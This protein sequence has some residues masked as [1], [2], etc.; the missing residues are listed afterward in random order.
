MRSGRNVHG[1]APRAWAR[2]WPGV[3]VRSGCDQE[4]T[5]TTQGRGCM[6][7]QDLELWARL[8]WGAPWTCRAASAVSAARCTPPRHGRA[9]GQGCGC[10][11]E[12]T[13]TTRGRR[14]MYGQELELWAR[15]E[16]VEPWTGRAASAAS[17]ASAA[18]CTP[19]PHARARAWPGVWV[20]SGRHVSALADSG[21]TPTWARLRSQTWFHGR[22]GSASNHKSQ[23]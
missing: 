19:S 11:P 17:A 4:G 3:R 21:H 10:D 2:A 9:R 16:W 8:E 22:E 20:Q 12:G 13:C 6:C 14:C 7:S 15:L 18:R 23:T 5:C 1:P